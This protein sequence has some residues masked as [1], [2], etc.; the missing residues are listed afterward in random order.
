MFLFLE[1]LFPLLSTWKL[2]LKLSVPTFKFFPS[3]P[4]ILSK[5]LGNNEPKYALVVLHLNCFPSP[6]NY[7]TTSF[8]FFLFW[9]L[10]TLWHTD[11]TLFYSLPLP[12]VPSLHSLVCQIPYIDSILNDQR[13][14]CDHFRSLCPQDVL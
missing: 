12:C 13:L 4:K 2:S 3:G 1:T 11:F 10:A 5:L 14:V 8:P 7:M 9:K 6:I